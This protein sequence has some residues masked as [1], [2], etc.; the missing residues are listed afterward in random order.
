MY[1]LYL[2]IFLLLVNFIRKKEFKKNELTFFLRVVKI[3]NIPTFILLILMIL[4]PIITIILPETYRILFSNI[5]S[6]IIDLFT[7]MF[8]ISFGLFLAFL[9]AKFLH[10]E[11]IKPYKNII[12]SSFLLAIILIVAIFLLIMSI[13]EYLENKLY[14]LIFSI[15]LA[16]ISVLRTPL[17]SDLESYLKCLPEEIGEKINKIKRKEIKNKLYYLSKNFFKIKEIYNVVIAFSIGV[18]L[19]NTMESS[20]LNLTINNTDFYPILPYALSIFI[21]FLDLKYNCSN[22]YI[23]SLN[24]IKNLFQ[25]I[26]FWLNNDLR[27]R[28]N[29]SLN[30][31]AT[32]FFILF[33]LYVIF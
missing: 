1:Y 13:N 8:C 20:N 11:S 2:S 32:I 31:I 24:W 3:T 4:L 12:T 23:N 30:W 29:N 14:L 5:N 21:I 33:F 22:I 26:Y 7:W 17:I 9:C 19:F 18:V 27:V 10:K 25:G 6:I 16:F 15:F 28:I